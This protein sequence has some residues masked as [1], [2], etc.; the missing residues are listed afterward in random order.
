M[1]IFFI[2]VTFGRQLHGQSR[3]DS[4]VRQIL[5]IPERA[6]ARDVRM[7]DG[8][9]TGG[10]RWRWGH[11]AGGHRRLALE[12]LVLAHPAQAAAIVIPQLLWGARY[13]YGRC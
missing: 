12:K 8:G 11:G 4:K 10:R 1:R 6:E 5:V 9:T 3:I 7:S 2:R 13:G